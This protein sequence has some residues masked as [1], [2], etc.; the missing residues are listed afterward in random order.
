M[1][2]QTSTQKS[3]LC[4][5]SHQEQPKNLK[6]GLDLG[7]LDTFDMELIYYSGVKVINFYPSPI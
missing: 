7:G 2:R 5:V 3:G 1:T 6:G 4:L